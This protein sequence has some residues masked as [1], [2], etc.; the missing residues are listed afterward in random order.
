MSGDL[1]LQMRWCQNTSKKENQLPVAVRGSPT[2]VLKLHIESCMGLLKDAMK[3]TNS[4]NY[5]PVIANPSESRLRP[6]LLGGRPW[7]ERRNSRLLLSARGCLVSVLGPIA[8]VL[9]LWEV[10]KSRKSNPLS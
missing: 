5:H 1:L 3:F 7:K 10:W 4:E 8:A 2:S 9:L 6:L